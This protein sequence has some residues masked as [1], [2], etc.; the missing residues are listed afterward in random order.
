M[1]V[2]TLAPFLGPRLALALG[3]LGAA[4][5]FGFAAFERV[6]LVG[7]SGAARFVPTKYPKLPP[8]VIPNFDYQ[9]TCH[10]VSE[11]YDR[12]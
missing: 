8:D 1:I 7:E 3:L 12:S 4:E 6:S 11:I 9:H 2:R 10:C 5:L